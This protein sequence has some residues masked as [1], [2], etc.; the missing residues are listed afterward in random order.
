LEHVERNG[1]HYH[2]G[3]T[4]LPVEQRLA[5]LAAH[6][7]FY[8]EQHGVVS[9]RVVNGRFAIGS[10]QCLGFGFA[11]EPDWGAYT[12]AEV[13]RYESLWEAA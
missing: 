13:W 3:L 4:Y 8:A 6:G 2:P 10:L 12:P 11:V 5:A 1:H 9:P 7:D